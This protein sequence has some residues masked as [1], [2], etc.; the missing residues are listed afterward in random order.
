MPRTNSIESI[1]KTLDLAGHELGILYQISQ[2]ISCSLDLDQVLRQIIDL[3]IEVTRGDSCLVYLLDETQQ[4][5][6]LRASKN[7][8]PRI[9]GNISLKVGEGITGWVAREAKPVAIPRH[10]SKDA[11]FKFFHN[12]PGNDIYKTS[13]MGMRTD[14]D[15]HYS[16][17]ALPG[18]GVIQ[19]RAEVDAIL[20]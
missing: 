16:L 2:S 12:L 13:S 10:A 1:R 19:F 17:L 18:S 6:V 9:I 4:C 20:G 7:P 5:L 3:V 8:H 15:G 14:K 11:R